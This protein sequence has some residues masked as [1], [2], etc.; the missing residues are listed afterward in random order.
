[1]PEPHDESIPDWIA[2][3][4]DTP[5]RE[6]G[7]KTPL[8]IIWQEAEPGDGWFPRAIAV[9]DHVGSL[10]A[11]ARHLYR[12]VARVGRRGR[13]VVERVPANHVFGSTMYEIAWSEHI[14]GRR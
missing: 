5:H 6:E 11:N 14:D 10:E 1:M 9:A 4:I 12:M 2:D 8:C 3:L 13:T 7:G